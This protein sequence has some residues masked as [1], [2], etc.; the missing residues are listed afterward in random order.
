MDPKSLHQSEIERLI[1]VSAESRAHLTLASQRLRDHLNVPAKLRD[2]LRRHPSSWLVGSLASGFVASLLFG[3]PRVRRGQPS[4]QGSIQV[5]PKRPKSLPAVAA[6]LALSAARP[7]A[8]RWLAQQA[9]RFLAKGISQA[10]R[11]L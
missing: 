6:G 8:T 4:T 1:R 10:S 11:R 5:E 3:R 9:E 7:L 2:S